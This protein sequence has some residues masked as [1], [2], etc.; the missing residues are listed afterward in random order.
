MPVKVCLCADAPETV[1]LLFIDEG[2]LLF[3][4]H[5]QS[6]E[7]WA[8]LSFLTGAGEQLPQENRLRVILA[9]MYG[10]KPSLVRAVPA[11]SVRD[12]ITYLLGGITY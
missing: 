6:D 9:V 8:K 5:R 4:E 10:V 2:H 3:A 1:D 7:L 12:N 11:T